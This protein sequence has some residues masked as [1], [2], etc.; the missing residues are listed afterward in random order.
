[1]NKKDLIKEVANRTGL[2]IRLS[3][4]IVDC[5]V[6]SISTALKQGE[7]VVLR[8]FGAFCNAEKR[9]KH[10]Y[11]IHTGK[12]ETSPSKKVVKFVPYKRFKGQ[13]A[14][15]KVVNVAS[16]NDG[17][18]GD[19]VTVEKIY[20]YPT[21]QH[22]PRVKKGCETSAKATLVGKNIGQRIDRSQEEETINVLFNGHFLF[23]HF[24]GENEHEK[25]PS[26]KVPQKDIPV[27][28]P[29]IDKIGAT[30]GVMEPILREHLINS[31]FGFR[32]GYEIIA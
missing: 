31:S 19:V 5:F 9:S 26:L 25:F 3:K 32:N 23:D 16:K 24:L 18:I 22:Y 1:M 20:V 2:S 10:Y 21:S 4:I 27:L 12:I 8:D 15:P 11:D 28:T 30:I 6:K 13:L 14:P 7:K 29:H 17:S